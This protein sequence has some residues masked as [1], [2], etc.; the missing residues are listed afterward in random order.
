MKHVGFSSWDESGAAVG[1]EAEIVEAAAA[2]LGFDVEWVE[3]PFVELLT[4]VAN[5][6]V[7]VAVSTI[8][9]TA[10]RRRRVAFS[11]PYFETQI[12]A[13]VRDDDDAPSTLLEL[14]SARIGAEDFSSSYPAA[15]EQWPE[16]TL[17][18]EQPEGMGWLEMVDQGL[19]DAYVVDASDQGRLE[20]R[21]GIRLRRI[22]AP[23][24][25]EYFG[26]AMQLDAVE[27]REAVN[28]AIEQRAR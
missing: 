13:L 1:I 24:S 19:I 27:L 10:E 8:G 15:S 21:A 12:V 5:G 25:A 16:A 7:D 23:L 28:R 14:S 20:A 6:E 22:E 26:V 2:E 4:A 9:I 3:R 18:V 17:V 11:K